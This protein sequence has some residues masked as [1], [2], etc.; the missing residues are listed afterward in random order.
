MNQH[1]LNQEIE[2]LIKRKNA[3]QEAYSPSELAFISQYEGSGGQGGKGAK[4]EGVLYEYYTPEFICNH[5]WEL[6]RHHGFKAGESVLEP[7]CGT[8]R[9]FAGAP[10]TSKL[11]GFE[12]NEITARI[13][14]LNYPEA[15]IHRG[16]FETAFL[17]PP[18]FTGKMKNGV[19][20]LNEYPFGLVI[21][22]P[23]YGKY[24][25][26]F[27]SYFPKPKVLQIEIFFMYY[28]LLLLKSGG[29]LVYITSSGFL[30]NGN[31][32][33]KPKEDLAK[34]CDLIDAYRL[35]PVFA[36]TSVPTDILVFRKK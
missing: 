22:N 17:E 27:S 35:P 6:A 15:T 24:K 34:L 12:I 26:M 11:V 3:L 8:G 9:F 29:L 20:W 10:K 1:Q 14:E 2:E 21:G 25:N 18:R 16:Y 28:G 7:S 30:R 31:T 36:S 23:P 4:G 5:M 13:A 19:T 33:D 32:Y